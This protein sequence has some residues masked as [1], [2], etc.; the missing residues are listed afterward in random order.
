MKY[1]IL[2]SFL[3]ILPVVFLPIFAQQPSDVLV[4]TQIILR[5]SEGNLVVSYEPTKIGYLNLVALNDFLDYESSPNDPIL[6]IGNQNL[7]NLRVSV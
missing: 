4:L 7:N 6:N 3:A 2:I 5:D 1:V